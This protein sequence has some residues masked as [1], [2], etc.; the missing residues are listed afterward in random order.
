[1]RRPYD[2]FTRPDEQRRVSQ[3]DLRPASGRSSALDGND[4]CDPAA[5]VPQLSDLK[6]PPVECANPVFE[7]G[8]YRCW[9]CVCPEPRRRIVP[10]RISAVERHHRVVITAVRGGEGSACQLQDIGPRALFQHPL[11]D[12]HTREPTKSG[13][14]R[15]CVIFRTGP[16]YREVRYGRG[17]RLGRPS[18]RGRRPI[19]QGGR[20][21]CGP[22]RLSPAQVR[23]EKM[24]IQRRSER[25]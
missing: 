2:D 24:S 17:P 23:G 5:E 7:E 4:P 21:T 9:S 13:R 14:Y 10:H 12:I 20:S 18:R 16:A 1:M 8:A 11:H 3:L 6:L 25:V 15:S 22:T 19:A